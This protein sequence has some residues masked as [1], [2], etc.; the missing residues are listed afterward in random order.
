MPPLP[1]S[2]SRNS[3]ADWPIAAKINVAQSLALAVLFLI[4]IIGMTVWLT[5]TQEEKSFAYMRQTTQQVVD[6]IG[7]YNSQLEKNAE[8]LGKVLQTYYPGGFVLD[9]HRT[10]SM[11]D[12]AVP[13]L[14]AGGTTL[15]L[16]FEAVDRFTGVTGAVATV[17][18]RQGDD[19]VRVATSLKKENGERAVGTQLGVAHP[20]HDRLLKGESFRGKARLFGRD[21]MTYYEPQRDKSG[22]VV[23]VLF[24]GLD[25]T[26]ELEALK[27]KIAA[28]K[29]G[30][31]GY[32]FAVDGGKDKGVLS[33]HP[34]KVGTK[35]YEAKDSRGVAYVKE[36]VDQRNG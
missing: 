13:V 12:K 1:N 5:R 28:I 10:V 3:P 23:A 2:P 14:S 33:I 21:Y 36:I 32:V 31:S 27:Q 18:A 29:F 7:A 25:F 17:F 4:A 11:G 35:L 30:K 19:F 34:S 24:I 6:S 22:Q 20:A 15:N 8:R 16:N 26:G 9:E